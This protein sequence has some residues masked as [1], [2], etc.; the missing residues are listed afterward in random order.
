M[1]ES[2]TKEAIT[3]V[4][5]KPLPFMYPGATFLDEEEVNAVLE[6][7]RSKS[8]FR[9]YGPKLLGIAGIF[10]DELKRY[11]GSSY[12]LGVC[13]GTAALHASLVGLGVGPG[14]EVIIPTYSWVSC[15]SVVVACGATP[16]LANIDE[17][18]TL[19]PHDVEARITNRTKAIM[20]VHI[21]GAPCDL[22]SLSRIAKKYQIAILEDAAQSVGGSYRGR[23]LGSIGD[24]GAFSFQLNKM[25]TAGEGGAVITNDDSI[26]D[27][28]LMFHDMAAPYRLFKRRGPSVFKAAIPGINYRITE[29]AAAILRVQLR[30][31]DK[32]VSTIRQNKQKIKKG[33]SDVSD[34]RFRKFHDPEGEVGVALTL[35]FEDTS[36]ANRFKDA[37]VAAG[38]VFEGG[39]YPQIIYDPT[40]IDGHV[41]IRWGHIIRG[42]ERV[43]DMY[44]RSLEILGR[45]VSI[46]VS[47]LLTAEDINDLVKAVHQAAK[48]LA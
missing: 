17:S 39:R 13:S 34:I 27:R 9:Y 45:T 30:K 7:I 29:V 33:I 8:L 1:S 5:S 44:D 18:L 35:F 22:D 3:Q 16:V 4:R 10:E 43:K 36:K 31:L 23:K 28:A 26:Y 19:D 14:D 2:R 46:D 42:I 24:V 41:F 47:P 15:P 38:T 12:A 6:V 21:L 48:V 11:A 20:A 40:R 32:I 25:I 37:L